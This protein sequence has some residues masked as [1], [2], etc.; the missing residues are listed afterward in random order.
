MYTRREV[1]FLPNYK[2]MYLEMVRETEK[3]INILIAVQRKC[4][5]Q[6]IADA[7]KIILLD[8]ECAPKEDTEGSSTAQ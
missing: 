5:E 6:V 2:E 3:A 7:P 4:E 8:K 1:I